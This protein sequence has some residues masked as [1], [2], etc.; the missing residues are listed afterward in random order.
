M[1]RRG[2]Y[3]RISVIDFDLLKQLTESEAKALVSA[4]GGSDIFFL[5][6]HGFTNFNIAAILLLLL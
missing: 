5:N 6:V 3:C 4:V 2:N 1:K